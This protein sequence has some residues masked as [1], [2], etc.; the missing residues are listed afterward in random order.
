MGV[1]NKGFPAIKEREVKIMGNADFGYKD[2]FA[3]YME[4]MRNVSCDGADL[5]MEISQNGWTSLDEIQGWIKEK[6]YTL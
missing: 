6:G 2:E 3:K 1:K 5:S 4:D